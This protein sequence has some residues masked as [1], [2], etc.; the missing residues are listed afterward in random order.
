MIN[1]QVV[2]Y[3]AVNIFGDK[4]ADDRDSSRLY[5]IINETLRSQWGGFKCVKKLVENHYF[6]PTDPSSARQ[7]SNKLTKL[8]KEEWKSM[9]E[10]GISQHGKAL[11][12]L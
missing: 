4:L 6:I 12:C 9:V 10:L 7:K 8:T 2:A 1:F 5:E 3:E 11:Y